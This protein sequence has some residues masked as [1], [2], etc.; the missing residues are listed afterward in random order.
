MMMATLLSWLARVRGTREA[1]LGAAAEVRCEDVGRHEGLHRR[2]RRIKRVCNCVRLL[3]GSN[4]GS[5][6]REE[7]EEDVLLSG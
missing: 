2:R 1:K 4:V 5:L 6:H 7:E 3:V